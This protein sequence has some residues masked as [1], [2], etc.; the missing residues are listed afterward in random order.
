MT[1]IDS[2]AADTA[3]AKQRIR[4]QMLTL[5][6]SIPDDLAAAWSASICKNIQA[7][8]QYAN[9]ESVLAYMPVKGEVSVL[10]LLAQA[11][12]DQKQVYLPAVDAQKKEMWFYRIYSLTGL[13]E[14][15]FHIPEPPREEAFEIKKDAQVLVLVP[16]I[17]FTRNCRRLGYGGGYYDRFL[18]LV[19]HAYKAAPAYEAQ[20]VDT[21]P[22]ELTD[23][24]VDA[25]CTEVHA[26]KRKEK[27]M[28]KTHVDTD[29]KRKADQK[30]ETPL[31]DSAALTTK[32]K[33]KKML[34]KVACF[35]VIA[36][37]AVACRS[38]SFTQI[39]HDF[40]IT[41]FEKAL[42]INEKP[43]DEDAIYTLP[44]DNEKKVPPE[45][46]EP[47]ITE[48]PD[49]SEAQEASETQAP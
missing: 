36:G 8:P 27:P 43:G 48:T 16:G 45:T 12:R 40:F 30:A 25:V 49:P 24:P 28:K 47:E 21:L 32:E 46:D 38:V 42:G 18:P 4:R 33:L 3:A 19:P 34:P 20:L 29:A 14:G 22:Q 37:I 39:G 26:I 23:L 6:K 5:R 2:A 10:E 35:V 7:L 15:V 13:Q 44:P 41:I 31:K 1:A 9:A 17:A 11:L